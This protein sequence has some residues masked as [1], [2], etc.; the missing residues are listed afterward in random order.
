MTDQSD[1]HPDGFNDKPLRSSSYSP[2]EGSSIFVEQG[3]H[4]SSAFI[5]LTS[6]LLGSGFLF[7]FIAKVDQSITVRGELQ[8]ADSV[9]DVQSPTAGVINNVFVSE[10]QKVTKGTPLLSLEASGLISRKQSLLDSIQL[11]EIEISSLRSLIDTQGDP[12]KF[13]N[14]Q[15]IPITSGDAQQDNLLA[16]RDQIIQIQSQLLQVDIRVKSRIQSLKLQEQ[17]V[18]DLKP[19]F[20]SGAVSRNNYLSKVNQIQVLTSDIAALEGEREKLIGN[21]TIRLASLN[22]QLLT[23]KAELASLSELL[24][25]KT[26]LS[27]SDGLVFNLTVKPSSVVGTSESLLDIVPTNKLMAR[28]AISNRDIGFVSI[29]QS[30]SVSVDSFPSGE[31]GYI[32]G[33][34]SSLVQIHYHPI[35]SALNH[36]FLPL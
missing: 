27:P 36:I 4:W 25:Y 29:G 1:N 35:P 34:L 24:K 11:L 15:P 30:A 31:F 32:S 8:P 9:L 14:L 5:W 10:G 28:V 2:W 16:A 23:S 20:L 21:S 6:I 33:K 22:R 18:A 26:I 13:R 3:R 19:L 12:S 7:A 17:I